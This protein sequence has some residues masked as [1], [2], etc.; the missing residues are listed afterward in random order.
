MDSDLRADITKNLQAKE[1]EELVE[2]WQNHDTDKWQEEVFEIIK[3]LLLK[4]LGYLPLLKPEIQSEQ[5]LSVALNKINVGEYDSAYQDCIKAIE[6]C[7]DLSDAYYF[8]GVIYEEQGQSQNASINFRKAISLDSTQKDYRKSFSRIE[9]RLK[10]EFENSQ[11]KKHIDQAIVFADKNEP[12]KG[13]SECKKAEELLPDIAFAYYSIGIAYEELDQ[14]QNALINFRKAITKDSTHK[15]SLNSINRIESIL[16]ADF[17]LSQG[18]KHLD[19]ALDFAYEDE[20]DKAL[21]ECEKSKTALPNIAVAY[22]YLGLVLQ[23]L[24]NTE[25]A[26]ESY[27]TATQLNPGFTPAWENLS[28]AKRRLEEEHYFKLAQRSPEEILELSEMEFVTDG[29]ESLVQVDIEDLIPGWY[30]M[31]AYAYLVPGTPGYRTRP[32]RSG[33]DIFDTDFEEARIEGF[34]IKKIFTG[35]FRTKNPFDLFV[36][37]LFGLFFCFPLLFAFISTLYG[38]LLGNIGLLILFSPLWVT[39]LAFWTNLVLSFTTKDSEN[40]NVF[41]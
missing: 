35:K 24:K 29:E 23:T 32:G 26:I 36:I 3:V 7:P 4:R 33:Y 8:L 18:K 28:F 14:P 2:I 16:K 40:F 15:D 31:D 10:L 11:A 37:A 6:L 41:Y 9:S 39:G 22:N 17:D 25:S 30:Y 38:S 34:V 21:K 5:L 19:Q 13:I 12:E 27:T 20:P 1:T